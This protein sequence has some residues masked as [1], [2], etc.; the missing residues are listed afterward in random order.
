MNHPSIMTVGIRVLFLSASVVAIYPCPAAADAPV[1]YLSQ[2]AADCIIRSTQGWGQMGYDQFV[3]PG[4][5]PPLPLRIK[6]TTYKHGLGHHANGEILLDLAGRYVTFQAEVGVL[7]QRGDVGSVVF[8]VFVDDEKKFE[9]PVMTDNDVALAVSVPVKGACELRLVA[10][11]AGDGITCDCAVWAEARL[12]RDPNA[13]ARRAKD[14]VDLAPFARVVTWDPARKDGAR[15]KRAM[16]FSKDDV[17]LAAD[18]PPCP[19]G[20]YQVPAHGGRHGCIGL[21]WAEPRLVRRL[22]LSLADADVLPDAAAIRVEAWQG[23]SPWQGEWIAMP[24]KVERSGDEWVFTPDRGKGPKL[25]AGLQMV[26]WIFP[27]TMKPIVVKRLAAYTSQPWKTTSLRVEV[28]PPLPVQQ[29]SIEVYN[30]QIAAPTHDGSPLRCKWDLAKPLDLQIRY[31][32]ARSWK[33]DRTVLRFSLPGNAFAVAVDDVIEN[34]CVYVPSA[35]LF[36]SKK[37]APVSSAQFRHQ[38]AEKKTVL[39]RV[40]QMPDQTFAQAMEKVHN[41]VQNN[42][43][44]LLS[45]ACDNRKFLVEREGA[46]MYDEFSDRADHPCPDISKYAFRMISQYGSGKTRVI[47]RRLHGDWLPVVETTVK[48]DGMIYRQRTF[49]APCDDGPKPH[50]PGWM[51]RRPVCVAQLAV[52]NPQQAEANAS[53]NFAFLDDTA[54]NHPA[55]LRTTSLGVI[56]AKDNRLLGLVSVP[57]GSLLKPIVKNGTVLVSATLPARQTAY[58]TVYLPGWDFQADQPTPFPDAITL[59]QRTSAYWQDVLAPAMQV[60][61]PDPLLMNV[62]RASQVHCMLAARNEAG[63]QRIAAW[64]GA[65]RYGPLESEANAVIRGMGLMGN[66]AFAQRSLDYHIHR[67]NAYGYLTMGYTIMGTG[68][69]LWTLADHYDRTQD[70][71]WLRRNA[72]EIARV[73]QWVAAQCDKTKGLDGRGDKM[74]EYGLVPPGVAAD[75]NRYAYRYVQ[76]A[77]Y[78][79][80]LRDAARILDEVGHP[81]AGRLAKAA[82]EFRQNILRAYRWTQARCP[83][84]PLQTG[85]SVP[86]YPSMLYAFGNLED[87]IP[88]E[89]GNRSWCYDVELGAHHLP[90]LGILDPNAP[91]VGGMLDHME[92]TWF[93]HSGMGDYA[94][95]RNHADW[96]SLG[97]FAKVQPYYARN[98]ELY[99]L[100]D[101]VKPFIRSYFNTIPSLLN[102]EN[103]A[104]WEHFGNRGAWHKPHETGYFLAQ[105]RL[106]L[107]M[108]RGNELWLAPFVTNK[109]LKNGMVVAVHGAPTTFGRVSYR[110]TSSVDEGFIEATVELPQR[111]RPD[112]VVLRLRHPEDKAIQKVIVNGKPQQAVDA[113]KHCVRLKPEGDRLTVRAVF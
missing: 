40:R 25:L 98:A 18:V 9:S 31:D 1:D 94:E 67:Y 23:E 66:D 78:C 61:L 75:W 5:R 59:L 54:K 88:G 8:R 43:P 89:D 27:A 41:P 85:A 49:V 52:E 99:A 53:A 2:T 80:G 33:P 73:C 4:N 103:L 11:D 113:S 64:V 45:L 39:E 32:R 20:T 57:Q 17:F 96:F 74:P 12:T 112:Q 95:D 48:V 3:V 76:E 91:E 106:M 14:T 47:T 19:N 83:V 55:T 63:G 34:G 72:P 7:R 92:D 93:L 6:D 26:R 84:L 58:C 13:K 101:D 107:V 100:R 60:E 46:V 44:T 37:D 109:W 22:G 50:A 86:A 104:F 21:K 62:I 24:T 71:A 15:S 90:V 16:E 42:G 36:V 81:E 87:M 65:D 35:G 77:H 69:H 68:W 111:K 29:V 105:T 56:A 51:D 70:K 82:T 108:E 28:S 110:I 10:D 38:V 102:L 30:G 79:A 97:G